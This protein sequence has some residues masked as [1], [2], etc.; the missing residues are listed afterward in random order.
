MLANCYEVFFSH[1]KDKIIELRATSRLKK[2][3]F[4]EKTL[5][6]IFFFAIPYTKGHVDLVR[7]FYF[8]SYFNFCLVA[9]SY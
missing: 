4:V 8:K 5:G 7:I 1:M 3:H 6:E 2:C 9:L